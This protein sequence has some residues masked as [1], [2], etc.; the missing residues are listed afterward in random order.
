MSGSSEIPK[1]RYVEAVIPLPI[2]ALCRGDL[3]KHSASWSPMNK[4]MPVRVIVSKVTYNRFL[5]SLRE[6][7]KELVRVV[8]A[9]D[10][11]KDWLREKKKIGIDRAK[12]ERC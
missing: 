8:W 5:E 7:W 11:L 6:D 4:E 10:S 1:G 9:G 12:R 3:K 2:Y